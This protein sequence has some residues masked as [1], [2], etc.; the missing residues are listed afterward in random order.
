MFLLLSIRSTMASIELI[1]NTKAYDFFFVFIGSI[2]LF[3]QVYVLLAVYLYV[4]YF[5]QLCPSAALAT[6]FLSAPNTDIGC[7]YTVHVYTNRS[8]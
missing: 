5:S 1:F 3:F 8:L 4:M 6:V 2:V 7:S